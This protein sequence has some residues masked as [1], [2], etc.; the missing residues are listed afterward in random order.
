M[1]RRNVVSYTRSRADRFR[2]AEGKLKEKLNLS[3][4]SGLCIEAYSS[5]AKKW[6][7]VKKVKGTKKNFSRTLG[8]YASFSIEQAC[9]WALPLSIQ[10]SQG[11]MPPAA[12]GQRSVDS[13]EILFEDFFAAYIERRSPMW[14]KWSIRDH[15]QAIALPSDRSPAGGALRYFWGKSLGSLSRAMLEEW[16][17]AERALGRHS[18][19]SRAVRNLFA[20]LRWG[21]DQDDFD[22]AIDRRII[23]STSIR[24]QARAT[25]PRSDDVIEISEL[26][27]L[28]RAI[29][30]IQNPIIVAYLLT[31][32]LT[33]CRREEI[34][35]LKWSYLDGATRST[36][37]NCKRDGLVD[38][39]GGRSIPIGDYLWDLIQGL[40]RVGDYVF[41]SSRSSSGRLVNPSKSYA[42]SRSSHG[43]SLT[44][45]G[46]RR[47]YS[48]VADEL[49]IPT[50]IQHF[51]Q[52][53]SPQGVRE[54]HYKRRTLE[55]LRPFQQSIESFMIERFSGQ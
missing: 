4:V 30:S 36:R 51:L 35:S 22:Q 53:Q 42:K 7:F 55:Q 45:H 1:P 27:K 43:I 48:R 32:L 3:N 29:T 28:Y 17:V 31:T 21:L 10:C 12:D 41:S 5:G 49:E 13:P 14:G 9:E 44:I 37:I 39:G 26:G 16:L 47:V 19:T 15:K 20:A 8:D 38:E 52:G 33:G 54:R 11:V 46:F 6:A 18:T 23:E 24:V 25:R 40:P 34:M 2:C 50:P